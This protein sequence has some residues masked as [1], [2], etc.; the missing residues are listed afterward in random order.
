MHRYN[1]LCSKLSVFKHF[2]ELGMLNVHKTA[3]HFEMLVIY[4]Y[5][6]QFQFLERPQGVYYG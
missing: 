4:L 5:G 3:Q 6:L 1:L 2:S